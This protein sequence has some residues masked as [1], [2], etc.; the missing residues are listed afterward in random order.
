MRGRSRFAL[1]TNEGNGERRATEAVGQV[2]KTASGRLRYGVTPLFSPDRQQVNDMLNRHRLWVHSGHGCHTNGISILENVNGVCRHAIFTASDIDDGGLDYD[3]VFMN[4]C[5]STD[6]KYYPVF[7]VT[8]QACGG[9]DGPHPYTDGTCVLDIGRKLNAKNYV[10]WDCEVPR[11]LSVTIPRMLMQELD[12]TGTDQT[13]TVY[14]AVD[15]VRQKLD[16]AKP[17]YHWYQER[18][19]NDRCTS[20]VVLDLNRKPF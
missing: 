5:E 4:T 7:P 20:D 15:A 11:Q 12:S 10:G 19:N 6:M 2:G 1:V 17:A 8:P 13:R 16:R 9:W 3:L 14:D 18:L